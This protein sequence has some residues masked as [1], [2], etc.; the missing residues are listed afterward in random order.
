MFKDLP[1]NTRTMLILEPFSSVLACILN[2]YQPLYMQGN[3]LDARQIGLIA[4]L[5]AVS[6]LLNQ[7]VAAPVVNRLGRRVAL[8][9]MSLV[10]WS[11]PLLCWMLATGSVLFLVAAFFFSFSRIAALAGYCVVTEEVG[12]NQKSR[13]FGLLFI[14]A[15][16]GGL[17]TLA[18]GPV[19]ARFG[20]VHTIRVLYGLALV[21]MTLMPIW[22]SSQSTPP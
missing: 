21:S 13:V 8:L 4:T 16:I 11:I 18:A 12:E 9:T 2:F 22:G 14:I 7:C 1:H 10:C 6:G 3:G 5:A 19:I 15:T 17:G 20:L